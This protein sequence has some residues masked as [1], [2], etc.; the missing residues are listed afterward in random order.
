MRGDNYNVKLQ[1]CAGLKKGGDMPKRRKK[2]AAGKA[3][4][5]QTGQITERA[6]KAQ[7]R[8]EARIK[9][10]Q[11]DGMTLETVRRRARDE[12]RDNPKPDWR[13]GYSELWT[14]ATESPFR[15]VRKTTKPLAHWQRITL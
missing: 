9:K 2:K 11:N 7:A 1:Y 14:K 5:Q 12:M 3:Y 15:S 4:N 8:L 10:L 13:R 6:A